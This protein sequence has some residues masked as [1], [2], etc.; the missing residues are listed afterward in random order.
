MRWNRTERQDEAPIRY[1]TERPRFEKTRRD[2][3]AVYGTGVE[4][5]GC[6]AQFNSYDAWKAH[7]NSQF[8]IEGF[9]TQC[10][11]YHTIKIVLEQAWDETVE[12]SPAWDET[13]TTGY[14]CSCGAVK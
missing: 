11:G 3:D 9:D 14:T 10:A 2:R 12:V 8:E 6:F 1:G 7:S 5:N 4:C 13:V